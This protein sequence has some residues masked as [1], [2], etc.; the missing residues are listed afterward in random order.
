MECRFGYCSREKGV[1]VAIIH[2]KRSGNGKKLINDGSRSGYNESDEGFYFAKISPN[3]W[4]I[5]LFNFS[6]L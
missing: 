3:F 2:E 1:G 4:F 6:R 5:Y